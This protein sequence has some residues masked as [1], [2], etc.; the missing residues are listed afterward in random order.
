MEPATLV[1]TQIELEYGVHDAGLIV[2]FP[3]TPEKARTITYRY[4]ARCARYFRHDPPTGIRWKIEAMPCEEAIA[5]SESV[6]RILGDG[7]VFFG[8]THVFD[9]KPA[10]AHPIL[11]QS[12]SPANSHTALHVRARWGRRCRA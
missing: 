1:R 6:G 4:E 10:S 3:G 2:P 11:H 9:A 7:E 8:W 5:Y 12:A